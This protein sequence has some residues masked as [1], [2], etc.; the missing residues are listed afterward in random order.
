MSDAESARTP[1]SFAPLLERLDRRAAE[2]EA[3]I[4][5]KQERQPANDPHEVTDQQEE[6]TTK[7]RAEVR[8]AEI[9]RDLAELRDIALARE[10]IDAGSYGECIDCGKPIG[11]QRLHA[12]PT[13]LRCIACQEKFEAAQ[14]RVH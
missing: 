2:L 12:Q 8:S 10:R 14:R 11:E 4:A 1:L 7:V 6:A 9:E 13:A 3:E 5:A